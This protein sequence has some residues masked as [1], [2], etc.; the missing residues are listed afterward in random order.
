MKVKAI[1]AYEIFRLTK[2]GGV[3]QRSAPVCWLVLS[4]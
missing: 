3:C 4:L 1:W 2:F